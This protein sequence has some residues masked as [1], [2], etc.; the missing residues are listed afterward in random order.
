MALANAPAGAP[1]SRKNSMRASYSEANLKAVAAQNDLIEASPRDI[2]KTFVTPPTVAQRIMA[3]LK[4]KG[5]NGG[6]VP[7]G[8]TLAI[9]AVQVAHAFPLALAPSPRP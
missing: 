1:R 8:V 4:G 2:A 3:W 5:A 6:I 9:A 7:N